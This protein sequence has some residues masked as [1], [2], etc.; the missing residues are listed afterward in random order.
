MRGQ[1]QRRRC[2]QGGVRVGD[3]TDSVITA[4]HLLRTIAEIKAKHPRPPIAVELSQ[5]VH[6]MWLRVFVGPEGEAIIR[7][8]GLPVRIVEGTGIARSVYEQE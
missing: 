4:E 8:H 5:D 3:V 7:Y 2:R 6:D 1:G